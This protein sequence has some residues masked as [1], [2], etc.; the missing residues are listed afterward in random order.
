[1]IEIDPEVQ[2]T[3]ADGFFPKINEALN[4]IS[5][6][7]LDSI[8]NYWQ[9]RDSEKMASF[10]ERPITL[11]AFQTP[12]H[13]IEKNYNSPKTFK[14]KHDYVKARKLQLQKKRKKFAD[15]DEIKES[16]FE[17]KRIISH[18]TLTKL[19]E[20]IK[21]EKSRYDLSLTHGMIVQKIN[22]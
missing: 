5:S 19:P 16:Q 3:A 21:K 10:Q 6:V 8:N 4:D 11:T 12:N 22:E 1:M 17:D 20:M 9:F 7:D 14:L 2:R 18:H 13:K 15:L